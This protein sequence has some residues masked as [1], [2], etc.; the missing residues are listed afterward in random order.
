MGK[1]GKTYVYELL[2]TGEIDED[3]PFLVGLIDIGRLKKKAREAGIVD[4]DA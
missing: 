3:K 2:A 4:E 1:K